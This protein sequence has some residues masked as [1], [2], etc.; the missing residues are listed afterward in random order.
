MSDLITAPTFTFRQ[1]KNSNGSFEENPIQ[2]SFY[3]GTIELRQEG[4]Y[5]QDET[6]QLS[7]QYVN[8]LFKAIKKNMP[9]A[10]EWMDRNTK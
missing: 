4:D 7:P 8:A 3:N 1:G 5:E 10:K 6:V 2:V 9:E